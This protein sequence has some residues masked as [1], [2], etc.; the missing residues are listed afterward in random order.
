MTSLRL[1]L[2]LASGFLFAMSSTTTL[3]ASKNTST[4]WTELSSGTRIASTLNDLDAQTVQLVSLIKSLESKSAVKEVYVDGSV[5]QIGSLTVGFGSSFD[6][7]VSQLENAAPIQRELGRFESRIKDEEKS[8]TRVAG[9][10]LI[11][12]YRVYRELY[13]IHECLDELVHELMGNSNRIYDHHNLEIALP[14]LQHQLEASRIKLEDL[15]SKLELMTSAQSAMLLDRDLHQEIDTAK[16][17][18][19]D[20]KIH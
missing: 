13:F 12:N 6:R 20:R 19:I 8:K 11:R 7:T 2:A 9:K 16:K 4:T 15:H 3:V 18:N 17:S 10:C 5:L 1:F 14:E